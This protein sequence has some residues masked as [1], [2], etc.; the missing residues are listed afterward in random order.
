[1]DRTVYNACNRCP[2]TGLEKLI[3]FHPMPNGST[4]RIFKD[5]FGQVR[6]V[7]FKPG[8]GTGYA[9]VLLDQHAVIKWKEVNPADRGK[10]VTRQ[11]TAFLTMLGYRWQASDNQ[12]ASGKACYKMD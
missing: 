4:I 12:T 8:N 10:N 11:L 6:I 2:H 1:M 3:S 7:A 9:G 5:N